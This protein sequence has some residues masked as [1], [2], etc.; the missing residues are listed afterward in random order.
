M[1][2][3]AWSVPDDA[4]VIQYPRQSAVLDETV[5]PA[6]QAPIQR[7]VFFGQLREGKGIRI[8]L[9]ALD[10]LDPIEVSFLG[11]S[12]K[13]WP[14]EELMRR[15]PGARVENDLP[16]E[17]ALAILREPGTLAV[18]PSLLDNSPNTVAECIEQG[19]PFVAADTGGVP[20]LVAETDRDRVLC[21]PTAEALAE[22][23]AAALASRP[24]FAPAQSAGSPRDAV[25]AWLEL[26][27]RV[28]PQRHGKGRSADVVALV[29]RGEHAAK[30]ARRLA[31][32]TQSVG[33]DVV[34]VQS[35][36]A[37]LFQTAAEWV[38]FLDDED[39]PDDGML[40]ALVAAQAATGADVVTCA[41]RSA[42]RGLHLFLGDARA[43]GLVEN[44]Y[45]VVAL[46]RAT[47]AVAAEGAEG[48]SDPDWPLLASIALAGA[49]VISLP[50]ALSM[51]HGTPGSVADVPG[52]AVAVLEAFEQRRSQVDSL[53]Q[54]AATVAAAYLRAARQPQV[55]DAT[56]RALP[57]RVARRLRSVV[58]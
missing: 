30:R 56:G 11:G 28:T 37:G 43:L 34:H 46:V 15:V 42:T 32:H 23:L 22:K 2:A 33:T 4:H 53:P 18:M 16:R 3:H 27:E 47:L 12:S 44:Q 5:P 1:R 50:E 7:L 41:V 6:Q 9:D 36:R 17:Q 52:D 39:E 13:R 10:R 57:R 45:G 19:I 38:V 14:R 8:F 25:D 20:E 49:K 58:R 21:A 48:I 35:R 55:G 51:H 29:A 24:S 54:L 31:E 40:D 26:V